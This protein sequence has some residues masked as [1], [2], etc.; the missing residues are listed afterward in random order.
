M[1]IWE[2][3][4]IVLT[5]FEIGMCIWICDAVVYDGEVVKEN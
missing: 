2:G 5:I 1:S 4:Q 3:I